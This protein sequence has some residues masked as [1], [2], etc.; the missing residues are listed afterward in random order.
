M[1]LPTPPVVRPNVEWT[2]KLPYTKTEK[3]GV[4]APS[5]DAVV[6]LVAE[7]CEG[8][9]SKVKANGAVQQIRLVREKGKTPI[10]RIR[11][12]C[13][14]RTDIKYLVRHDARFHPLPAQASYD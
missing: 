1:P 3:G 6:K 2:E 8:F 10:L 14:L 4:K 11:F 7:A 5:I 12:R 13:N 9:T